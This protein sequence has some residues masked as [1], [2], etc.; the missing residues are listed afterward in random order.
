MSGHSSP[1][2]I[3][4]KAISQFLVE[5]GWRR[6]RHESG[7]VPGA[8]SFGERGIA[9]YQYLYY[10]PQARVKG[11]A[12]VL[13]VETKPPDYKP[14]CACRA[15]RKEAGVYYPAKVCRDCGQKR[16][17]AAERQRGALVVQVS[18]AEA[19]RRWYAE[20]FTWI[21]VPG[22]LQAAFD[23]AGGAA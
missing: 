16:W 11:A 4:A 7:F 6:V 10:V 21:E 15:A 23:F 18:D 14:R 19:F 3:V 5:R 22:K 1:E 9:D 13:W 12:L 2:A 17:Q 8:G 20:H